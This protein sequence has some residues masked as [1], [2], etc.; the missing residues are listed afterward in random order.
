MNW[1]SGFAL[2]DRQAAFSPVKIHQPLVDIIQADV[3]LLLLPFFISGMY[4][5]ADLFYLFP[6]DPVPGVAD[7][8]HQTALLHAALQQDPSAVFRRFHAVH[9][10]VFHKGLQDHLGDLIFHHFLRNTDLIIQ[11]PAEAHLVD[12]KIISDQP[13]LLL[14]RH[15]I[16]NRHAVAEDLSQRVQHPVG[17]PCIL[18]HRA[19]LDHLDRVE[20]EMGITGEGS[21]FPPAEGAGSDSSSARSHP[22]SAHPPKRSERSVPPAREC[23]WS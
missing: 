6:G 7:R 8:Q 11:L 14:Q 12:I 3:H 16:R 4:D 21:G 22:A 23:C 17:F 1:I 9:H 15:L 19:A 18:L 5:A 2:A 13:D 20:Q 10:R